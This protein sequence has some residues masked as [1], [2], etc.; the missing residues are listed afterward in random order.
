MR[1]RKNFCKVPFVKGS[2]FYEPLEKKKICVLGHPSL[3]QILTWIYTFS[4]VLAPSFCSRTMKAPLPTAGLSARIF[5]VRSHPREAGNRR[6]G[7]CELRVLFMWFQHSCLELNASSQNTGF[8]SLF[9]AVREAK[10]WGI[11]VKLEARGNCVP[12]FH[13]AR[14]ILL[15]IYWVL[16]MCHHQVM[17]FAWISHAIFTT[18]WGVIPGHILV[19]KQRLIKDEGTSPV[20][21]A[22]ECWRSSWTR[23]VWHQAQS[24]RQMGSV[25][26]V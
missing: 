25:G 9:W 23:A 4:R 17:P 5:S 20:S 11:W 3:S 10:H 18:V 6:G 7:S 14:R 26:R 19:R 15:N 24:E 21:T 1:T 2:Y 16:I 8:S 13:G 12:E 22:S